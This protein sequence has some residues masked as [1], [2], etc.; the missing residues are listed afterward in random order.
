MTK[1]KL[2]SL[3]FISI[4]FLAV[5]AESVFS[6][7]I[8]VSPGMIIVRADS[9]PSTT[10]TA[11]Y[12]LAVKNVNDFPVT[13]TLTKSGEISSLINIAETSF[14]LQ[15]NELKTVSLVMSL[16]GPAYAFGNINVNFGNTDQMPVY[17]DV[18]VGIYGRS[19]S[20]PPTQGCAGQQTACGTF[21]NS[22]LALVSCCYNGMKKN[23][24][25]SNNEIKSNEYCDQS[26]CGFIGGTCQSG[27]CVLPQKSLTVNITNRSGPI[28]VSVSLYSPG[29]SNLVSSANVTGV[30]TINY[31]NSTA[32]FKID[33]ESKLSI[34][35]KSMNLDGIT[36]TPNI[37]LDPVSPTIPNVTLKRAYKISVPSS[38]PFNGITLSI[39]YSDLSVNENLLYLYRCGDFNLTTNVCNEN[40]IPKSMTKVNGYVVAD[41]DSFSAYAI[42]EGQQP[43]V[44]T[45]TTIATTTT[46]QSSGSSGS[47]ESSGGS[48]G[49]GGDGGGG[50]VITT[51]VPTTTLPPVTTTIP[52]TTT[53]TEQTNE[54]VEQTQQ[55][56]MFS[57]F[58]SL[59]Y[60]N[61]LLIGLPVATAAAA[62][63]SW[64]FYLKNRFA[65][66]HYP[67]FSKRVPNF[68]T[69]K[70][71]SKE[72]RLIFQ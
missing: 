31:Y 2:S 72:T 12:S 53:T 51:T 60:S 56:S 24:W 64:K 9:Y 21:P 44:T 35:L 71:K 63:L 29:T 25:C 49:G 4:L 17:W 5:S 55:P 27:T 52:P 28:S 47:P 20:P 23:Y 50:F 7:T 10:T 43:P 38:L 3:V 42:G 46:V 1:M 41:L 66:P 11:I 19:S 26:C 67:R 14:V 68:N 36:T 69:K 18:G 59:V 48:G 58:F 65:T 33:H 16:T 32:D 34:L 37:V 45:T 61:G 40:W 70:R 39:R 13:V 15:P 22:S 54:T 8:W 30:G 62:F 6:T 57:G